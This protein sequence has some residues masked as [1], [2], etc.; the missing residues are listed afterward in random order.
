MLQLIIA[1]I[2]FF[3]VMFLVGMVLGTIQEVIKI[4]KEDQNERE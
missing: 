2:L 4:Y 3:I 1:I